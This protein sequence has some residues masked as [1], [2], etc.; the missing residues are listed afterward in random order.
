MMSVK[1]W[2]LE[3]CDGK[4]PAES[5]LDTNLLLM[6]EPNVRVREWRLSDTTRTG[7][8]PLPDDGTAFDVLL[9]IKTTGQQL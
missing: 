6:D 2:V 1:S 3:R 7:S 4:L 8:F 9:D 5:T